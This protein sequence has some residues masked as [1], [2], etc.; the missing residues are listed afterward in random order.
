MSEATWFL[1]GFAA[2]AILL[3]LLLRQRSGKG[4]QREMAALRTLLQERERTE[5]ESQRQIVTL[6]TRL[7]ERERAGENRKKLLAEAEGERKQEQAQLLENLR[8]SVVAELRESA[9]QTLEEKRKSLDSEGRKALDTVVTP[10]KEQIKIYQERIEKIHSES[11]AG[12]TSVKTYIEQ[13]MQAA[14]GIGQDAKNLTQA[15]QGKSQL[16]GSWGEM[17]LQKMLEDAGLRE[18]REYDVQRSVQDEEG[19]RSRPDVILHL[20]GKRDI[21]IDSKVSLRDWE[22]VVAA[23]DEETRQAALADHVRALRSHVR[24]QGKRDYQD[25][26]GLQTLDFVFLFMPIEPA[27]MAA[28]QQEPSLYQEAYKERIV[29]T[30]PTT[31]FAILRVVENLWRMEQRNRNAAEIARQGGFMYDKV[32]GFL[33]TFTSIQKQLQRATDSWHEASKQLRS[34]KGNLLSRAK[35]MRELG[36]PAKKELPAELLEIDEEGDTSDNGADLPVKN[37]ALPAAS[38]TGAKSTLPR[39]N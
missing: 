32:A 35:K 29:L 1:A 20:P 26:P 11:Q 23:P 16:R 18:G 19:G 31:L 34:G 2:G 4:G 9:G 36:V 24:D 21:I 10:L 37:T 27:F 25:L 15:L 5:A 17:V 13:L 38:S 22:R 7:E 8:K 12:T 28:M 6:Q 3:Y 30:S 14:Q 33:E 39:G